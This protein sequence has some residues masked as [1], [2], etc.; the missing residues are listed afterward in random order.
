MNKLLSLGRK[1][2]L[3][4][5]LVPLESTDYL[6]NTK[7]TNVHLLHQPTNSDK[8]N[9]SK[10]K[11]ISCLWN[12]K[13]KNPDSCAHAL[14]Y[15]QARLLISLTFAT[16]GPIPDTWFTSNHL[17]RNWKSQ[18]WHGRRHQINWPLTWFWFNFLKNKSLAESV[19]P[20]GE[21]RPDSLS[22]TL[23][24]ELK[25]A[26]GHSLTSAVLN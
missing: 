8:K 2:Q 9:L 4:L 5:Q 1:Q 14:V 22:L 15:I 25:V 11:T 24:V 12:G 23:L 21:P 16:M 7:W 26:G 10:S 6:K 18:Y 3:V 19:I 17:K 20:L 13:L